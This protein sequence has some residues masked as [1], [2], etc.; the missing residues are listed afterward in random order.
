MASEIK[1][2]PGATEDAHP[3]VF[4][5]Q[6]MPTPSGEKKPGQLPDETIKKFF[7]DVR[8]GLIL[9]KFL[10]LHASVIYF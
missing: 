3:E 9:L 8:I 1:V 5:S 2:Q 7:E 10:Y 6:A 4:N